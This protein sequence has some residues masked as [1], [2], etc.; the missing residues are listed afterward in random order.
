MTTTKSKHKLKKKNEKKNEYWFKISIKLFTTTSMNREF[1]KSDRTSRTKFEIRSSSKK[2]RFRH[3]SHRLLT[4]IY[5]FCNRIHRV[6]KRQNQTICY[7]QVLRDSITFCLDTSTKI[8]RQ[9]AFFRR[10]YELV[11]NRLR[12]LFW[13]SRFENLRT[14]IEWYQSNMR[15]KFYFAIWHSRIFILWK[16]F[17]QSLNVILF[18]WRLIK[19]LKC[20]RLKKSSMLMFIKFLKIHFFNEEMNFESRKKKFQVDDNM[21][22]NQKEN[23]YQ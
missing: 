9:T 7:D 15:A 5:D 13:T 23:F 19:F 1:E 17:K 10:L 4:F 12:R 8:S 6:I 20:Y 14:R 2:R 16:C 21:N 22:L 11:S 18:L 3:F